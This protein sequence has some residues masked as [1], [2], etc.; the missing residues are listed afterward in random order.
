MY[1]FKFKG[2]DCQCDTADELRQICEE[3]K[4][5]PTACRAAVSAPAAADSIAKLPFVKG[6][7][8]WIRVKRVARKL[9]REDP[10][11]LRSELLIRKKLGRKV[12]V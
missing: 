2:T 10:L 8:T 3:P 1:R 4:A 7:L 5:V 11:R 6:A 12:L 9:G